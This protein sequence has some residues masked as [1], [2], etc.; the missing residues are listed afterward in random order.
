ME[1]LPSLQDYVDAVMLGLHDD[2][3]S[4]NVEPVYLRE[5]DIGLKA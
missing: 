1:Y 4:Q 5:P 3:Q 2:A